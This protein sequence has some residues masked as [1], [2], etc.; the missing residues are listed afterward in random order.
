MVSVLNC[1]LFYMACYQP[2]CRPIDPFLIA[3]PLLVFLFSR[4]VVH[5]IFFE[6]VQFF[7]LIRGEEQFLKQILRYPEGTKLTERVVKDVPLL[8]IGIRFL[9]RH[10]A[11]SPADVLYQHG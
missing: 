1:L 7:Y 9:F 4:Q 3:G 2:L 5:A 10:T 8:S 6:I 11:A